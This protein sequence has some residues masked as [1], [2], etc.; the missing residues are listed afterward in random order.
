MTKLVPEKN[1]WWRAS[2]SFQTT[3]AR[4]GFVSPPPVYDAA[5][6]RSTSEMPI[7]TYLNPVK[8][9]PIMTA[10]V[11]IATEPRYRPRIPAMKKPRIP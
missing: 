4:V 9:K 5:T 3:F 6:P 2:L 8:A 10:K 1:V 7:T 11:R